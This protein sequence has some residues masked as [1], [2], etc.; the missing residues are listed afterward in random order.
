VDLPAGLRVLLA[1]DNLVNQHLAMRLLQSWGL[2][3]E[4][5]SNGAEALN[6]LEHHGFD[7]VLM[8]VQMPGMDGLSAARAIRERERDTGGHLPIIALT[9]H[10][11][12]SDRQRCLE[13]GMDGYVAKPID[14]Q[15]LLGA[16]KSLSVGLSPEPAPAEAPAPVDRPALI[17]R[18]DGDWA[19]IRQLV[20]IFLEECPKLL[21]QAQASL[22]SGDAQGLAVAAHTIKGSV[23]Y[24]EAPGAFA[25]AL[26]LERLGRAGQL[27]QARQALDSLRQILQTVTGELEKV[28]GEMGP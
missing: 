19:L 13:A 22:A 10:A 12:A 1:E 14:P 5:A 28:L 15:V 25:A 27:E 4:L 3:V 18:F 23:G 16:I 11:M 7:L 6:L 20:E 24:F 17:R 2:A 26:E 9:A 21:E 8:D